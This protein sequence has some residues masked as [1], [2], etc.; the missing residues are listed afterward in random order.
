M[1][2]IFLLLAKPE[3]RTVTLEA[4]LAPVFSEVIPRL[5]PEAQGVLA[6]TSWQSFVKPVLHFPRTGDSSALVHPYCSVGFARV[7]GRNVNAD[8]CSCLLC[9]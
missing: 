5:C 8:I 9:F 4:V 7:A 3:K 6:V 1:V 2:G